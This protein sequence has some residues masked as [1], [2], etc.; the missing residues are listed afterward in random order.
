MPYKFQPGN[1]N[2]E[3]SYS[4]LGLLDYVEAFCDAHGRSDL[5]GDT[6]AQLDFTFDAFSKHEEQLAAR[7]LEYLAHNRRVR[8]I[9]SPRPGR[10]ERVPTVSFVVDGMSSD[11]VVAETDPHQI[12]IRFGHFYAKRLIDDLGFTEQNGVVRVSMVHYNTLDEI[13]RLIDVLDTI[14]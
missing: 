8:V 1:V 14:L 9:G 5:K 2:Y 7:L 11:T 10:D 4:M 3:L 6:A 13:D 12:G